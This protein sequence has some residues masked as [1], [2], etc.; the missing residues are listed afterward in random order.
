M[1]TAE[2][3]RIAALEVLCPTAALAGDASYPTIA[4][5]RVFDSRAA[6]VADLDRNAKFT[7]V[8]ALYTPDAR[9]ALRGPGSAQNDTDAVAGLEIVAELAVSVSENGEDFADALAG[10]DW[11]AR[12]VL[13]ALCAQ[14]RWA[15]VYSENGVLF[16]RIV[17]QVRSVSEDTFAIPQIGARWHRVTMRFDLELP[18]DEFSDQPGLPPAVARL[19]SALP[20]A[21]PARL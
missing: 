1:L 18:D 3:A 6:A 12:L 9:S 13:A 10:D 11:E 17:R 15:L 14:V 4:G 20:D 5:Y 19:V 16:R 7:P 21:A 8:L 2:A